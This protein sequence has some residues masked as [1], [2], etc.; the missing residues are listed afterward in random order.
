[1]CSQPLDKVD[2][3]VGTILQKRAV[4]LIID[5]FI[6]QAGLT[7]KKKTKQIIIN[8]GTVKLPLILQPVI[9]LTCSISLWPKAANTDK[10]KNN[11]KMCHLP[12]VY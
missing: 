5:I 11:D 3:A 6:N 9:S 8:K 10:L 1:M 7:V 2:E 4:R 12:N